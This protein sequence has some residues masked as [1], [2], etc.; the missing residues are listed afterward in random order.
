[1][2][3]NVF[4]A[5][6]DRQPDHRSLNR[7]NVVLWQQVDFVLASQKISGEVDLFFKFDGDFGRSY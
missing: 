5:F 7:L 2:H 1:M 4:L 6:S 3:A